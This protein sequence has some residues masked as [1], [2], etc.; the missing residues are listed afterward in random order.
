M[1]LCP[2]GEV[3]AMLP[4]CC[5]APFFCIHRPNNGTYYPI[6]V[7][8]NVADIPNCNPLDDIRLRCRITG[9]VSTE[10]GGDLFAVFPP[11]AGNPTGNAF[12]TVVMLRA[13]KLRNTNMTR[14]YT[15]HSECFDEQGNRVATTKPLAAVVYV[16]PNCRGSDRT[17]QDA[18]AALTA[19]Q[20]PAG[21]G[22]L[23]QPTIPSPN[24]ALGSES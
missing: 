19:T 10:G 22:G 4:L 16:R 23:W 18:A 17:C 3:T 9:V 8:Y 11:G 2:F 12:P 24:L 1:G 13:K 20:Y 15:I 7:L 5:L 14:T 6:R 21:T